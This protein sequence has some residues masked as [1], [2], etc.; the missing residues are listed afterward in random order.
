MIVS[1]VKG[2][3]EFVR[4]GENGLT[5]KRGSLAELTGAIEKIVKNPKIIENFS[6][7]ADYRK[8]ISDYVEDIE[9]LYQEILA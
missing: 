7:Q 1:A 8:T 3:T 5:F 9:L 6:R 4:D 2:M